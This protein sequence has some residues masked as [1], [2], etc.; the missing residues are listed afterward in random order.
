[1]PLQ[2]DLENVLQFFTFLSPIFISVFFLFQSAMKG[3]L[4]KNPYKNISQDRDMDRFHRSAGE[5]R[6]GPSPLT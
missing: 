4:H 6:G 2:L 1:M 5:G 3:T